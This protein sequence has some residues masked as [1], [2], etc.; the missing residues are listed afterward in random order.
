ME[1]TIKYKDCDITKYYFGNTIYNGRTI[2]FQ[3]IKTINLNLEVQEVLDFQIVF[4]DANIYRY[5]N[6]SDVQSIKD[7]ITQEFNKKFK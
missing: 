1:L 6:A 4:S 7:S 2:D 3:I 5:L